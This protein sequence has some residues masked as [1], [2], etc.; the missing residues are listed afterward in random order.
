MRRH[1][2][3]NLPPRR[4]PRRRRSDLMN[5]TT[6][7]RSFSSIISWYYSGGV[8]KWFIAIYYIRLVAKVGN[9]TKLSFLRKQESGN[10][11]LY[12]IPAFAGMTPEGTF[13]TGLLFI[14]KL[15]EEPSNLL[16][17]YFYLIFISGA[18]SMAIMTPLFGPL[19]AWPSLVIGLFAIMILI[20]YDIK[21]VYAWI[22]LS[23]VIGALSIFLYEHHF[24]VFIFAFITNGAL[25]GYFAWKVSKR[26]TAA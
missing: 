10:S 26:Q 24:F 16:N 5:E 18:F 14:A 20:R 7:F 4:K 23:A 15:L 9:H 17:I 22:C 6:T 19:L 3:I 12:M 2:T 11:V 1:Q 25:T 8:F 21:S 13:A